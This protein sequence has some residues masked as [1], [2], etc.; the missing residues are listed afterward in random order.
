MRKSG[1][2]PDEEGRCPLQHLCAC[3]VLLRL[4]TFLYGYTYVS[5]ADTCQVSRP[6]RLK[7]IARLLAELSS[8]TAITNVKTS[9]NDLQD[10]R[11]CLLIS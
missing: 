10:V 8:R 11:D 9:G 1:R 5:I 3:V 7:Q 6:S 2:G 4:M